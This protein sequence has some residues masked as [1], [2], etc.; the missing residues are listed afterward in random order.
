[1]NI[2]LNCPNCGQEN[3]VNAKKAKEI[4]PVTCKKCKKS[5]KAHFTEKDLKRFNNLSDSTENIMGDVRIT[6]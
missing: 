1:M 2:P 6:F 4:T 5:F 3:N